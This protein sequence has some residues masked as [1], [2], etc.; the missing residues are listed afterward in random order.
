[1]A[2]H[3]NLYQR[4]VYYDVIFDR[5][6]SREA[7]FITQAYQ[8]YSGKPGPSAILDLACGPGYHALEFARRGIA[9]SGLDLGKEMLTL[10]REKSDAQGLQVDWIEADMRRFVLEH[11]VDAA[12][13]MFDGLD[14]LLTTE[15]LITHL[16][17]VA[18]NLHPDGI[19][20]IDLT[21]PRECSF[22][23]YGTF[24]Y[25]GKRDGME[26]EIRWATNHPRFDL[27]TGVADTE[28]EM[29]VTD[30]GREIVVK[31]RARERLLLPQEIGLLAEQS[32]VL[33]VVGWHGDYDVRQPLDH[34]EAS[35]RMI[36]VLQRA[37]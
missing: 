28:L 26:A 31:D 10:A 35:R 37:G 13:I 22:Q 19:Y 4:A 18:Q 16:R 33:R 3:M 27:V 5:D 32:G 1:M 17:A 7:D 21:H 2:E 30:H 9:A 25:H 8:R 11:P 6:V 20:I 12:F 15:D 34:S 29:H 24:R 23:K 14:A 36:A